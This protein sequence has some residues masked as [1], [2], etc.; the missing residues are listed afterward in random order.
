MS[1][2]TSSSFK[3][4]AAFLAGLSFAAMPAVGP[5]LAV[6][7]IFSGHLRLQRAD[8]WWWVSSLLLGLPFVT[9][10]HVTEGLLSSAQV[11][12]VWLLFRSATELRRSLRN[13]TTPID[14]SAGLVVGLAIT[15]ALG[16]R[17]IGSFRFD[18]ARTALD[19]I[20][21]DTHPALFG[22][23]ILVLSVAVALVLPPPRL[24]VVAMAIGAVGVVVS[25][26][27]EAVAAWLIVAVGL[28]FLGRRGT[29]S[30]RIAEWTLI[31]VMAL[32]ASGVAAWLGLG[33]TGFLTDV[34]PTYEPNNLFRGT[35]VARGDWWYPL[36]VTVSGRQ[37]QVDGATRTVF[38][39]TKV[40]PHPWSRLQQAVTL[41]PDQSYTLSALLETPPGSQP[42]FDG[43]GRVGDEAAVNLGMTLD[44]LAHAARSTGALQVLAAD[45]TPVGD[46]WVRA[47]VTF[48][49]R[50]ERPLTWYVGVVPDRSGRI[51]LTI[52][53]AELQLTPS[54][55]LLPYRPG[56][57]SRGVAD[58]RTSR[59]PIWRDALEA[60]AARPLL[61]WGPDGFPLSVA[62]LHPDEV[63]LRTL[64]AH[65]HNSL[66]AAWVDRGV[67]GLFGLLGLLV[68]LA[69]RAVQQRD[70]AAVL[71]LVGIVTLNLFDT[72]L[73]SGAVIYPLAAVLGW[74]AVGRREFAEAETGVGS[75][76][77]VRLGLAFADAVAGAAALS[78][79]IYAAGDYGAGVAAAGWSLPLLYATLVWPAIAAAA[80]L[81]P[82][83]GLPS[84]KKLARSVKAATAA[85]VVVGFL[86]LV[87]PEAF[88]L[89]ARVFIVT[90]PAAALLAPTFRFLAQ[91]ALQLLRL[92]GRPVV[93]LGTEPAAAQVTRHLLAH[94]DI[95]LHPMAVFGAPTDW[96]LA[97]LPI[98]GSLEHAWTYIENNEVRHAII[99]PAAATAATF[100]R[101]LLQSGAR[102]KYLQYLPDLRG[103]PTN[104]VVAAPLGPTLGLEVRNQLAST[105]NRAIKRIMDLVGASVLL[106]VLGL[107]LL[108]IGL[109]IRLDSR[110]PALYVSPRIGRYGREFGCIKFR[111][112]HVDA[113]ER[114]EGLLAEQ[115]ELRT[116]YE[117]FHK[118]AHDPRVTRIGR[119]L[120]QASLDELPQLLNV[121]A[122][123][124][125]LVGPRPYMVR[126]RSHMGTEKDVI[127][128][129]RPGMT[130]YWQTEARNEVSFEERQG[131][132]AH[133]VRNWSV[134]WDVDILLRTPGAMLERSGK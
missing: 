106:S 112:M 81:Y 102:L 107:P 19:A 29:R 73:L 103:L 10:G 86:A 43:W 11:L 129:A 65:A 116:E 23:A 21:W 16:L 13:T 31:V 52:S 24:R 70:R 128:L 25:G 69:T 18:V 79:G 76:T 130:G 68:L 132:E 38:E 4:G 92:W 20:V 64:A 109:L 72:T 93:V 117:R 125:S 7:A 100:D 63:P 15:L 37:E 123:Q 49:Y 83:Y 45:A 114:L 61:G 27:L 131:M 90:V 127:F 119:V 44:G 101:V 134:W 88:A 9:G 118:L 40:S 32:I 91:R 111:T 33:R 17:H 5:F 108:L 113:D 133:Y 56:A 78:L 2:R 87:T 71:V 115:P 50:G 105:T 28:R 42:G 66:L 77:V 48:R 96:P 126:E 3:R 67:I 1:A 55:A 36:G 82:A 121:F 51:G 58:L 95:G 110:G 34:A 14:I 39:V 53:F 74:R 22:H 60:I 41:S 122:G 80:G 120:R 98:T 84:H 75:A 30:T 85:A 97:A 35:E 124:M 46:G 94:P 89:P 59:F 12:A 99:S 104:S 57:A 6:T 54:G 8:A 47:S 26:A 62:T